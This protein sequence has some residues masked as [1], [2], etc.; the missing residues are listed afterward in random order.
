HAAGHGMIFAGHASTASSVVH[1]SQRRRE[2][3]RTARIRMRSISIIANRASEGAGT[4]FTNRLKLCVRALSDV[5]S[6][7]VD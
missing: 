5:R 7:M 2:P 3:I 4:A 6:D 1:R